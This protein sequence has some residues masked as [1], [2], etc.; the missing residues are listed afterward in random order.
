MPFPL[1]HSKMNYIS[2]QNQQ[3]I[4]LRDIPLLGYD[5]FYREVVDLMKDLLNRHCVNYFGY[6][7]D[8]KIRLICCIADDLLNQIYILST[9]VNSDSSL[10]SVTIVIPAFEKFERELHE[11]F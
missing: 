5:T 4:P 9:E 3:C 1:F 7:S 8:D 10:E 2:V 11:N 6:K